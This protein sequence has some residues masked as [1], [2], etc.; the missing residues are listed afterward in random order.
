MANPEG[1]QPLRHVLAFRSVGQAFHL[2]DERIENAAPY[3]GQSTPYF[4][5]RYQQGRPV[6]NVRT[7][8]RRLEHERVE[9]DL[10]ILAQRKDPVSYPEFW[11][12]ESAYTS[13]RIFREWSF[14]R[15]AVLRDPQ[16]ADMRNDRLAEDFSDLGLFLNRLRRVPQAKRAFL[17]ALGDLYEGVSDFDVS[18]E[19][20]TVQVFLTEGDFT[21]PA[22]RLSDGTLRYLC[23]LAIRS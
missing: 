15:R 7:D 4:Y 9:P 21:I 17:E 5:Y 2:E 11:Y 18:I 19:G 22:T 1:N 8:E 6:L 14:G 3:D 12:L 10:S 13:I 16:R 23:L 20:G